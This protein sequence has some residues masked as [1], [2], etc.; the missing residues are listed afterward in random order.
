MLLNVV[1][2][3]L[4]LA[5]RMGER[6]VVSDEV[7]AAIGPLFPGWKGNGRPVAERRLVVEGVAWKFRTGAPWR[8][9]PERFGNWDIQA[10][11][12]AAADLDW[13]RLVRLHD[14]AR[15]PARREPRP[16]H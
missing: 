5:G 9:V 15:A 6:D 14:R 3:V 1:G 11:G 12:D 13:N 7:W 10:R 4:R 2:L 8:D 16:R